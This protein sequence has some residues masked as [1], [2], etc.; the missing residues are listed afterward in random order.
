[1]N[2]NI[3]QIIIILLVFVVIAIGTA[4]VEY[5]YFHNVSESFFDNSSKAWFHE[6]FATSKSRFYNISYKCKDNVCIENET[7]MWDIRFVNLGQEV[8]EITS[9]RLMDHQSL[10]ELLFYNKSVIKVDPEMRGELQINTTAFILAEER[11]IKFFPCFTIRVPYDAWDKLDE[12]VSTDYYV[13]RV[14]EYCYNESYNIS[15]MECR[16]NSYCDED[17]ECKENLC[18]KLECGECQHIVEHRCVDWQCCKA[19]DCPENQT[20]VEHFCRKLFCKPDEIIENH[21]CRSCNYDEFLEDGKCKKLRCKDD[22]VAAN[23]SCKKLICRDNEIAANHSCKKLKCGGDEVAKNHKC[24]KLSCA[25]DEV[26]KNHKCVKLECMFF[27]E[28]R[29]HKCYTDKML[30]LSIIMEAVAWFIIFTV[31]GL[32]LK[33]YHK[34]HAT[35]KLL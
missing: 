14:L 26:A 19:E 16:D 7:I 17:E 5:D 9:L 34:K 29:N 20:C 12:I 4:G 30:V 25:E 21:S 10:E 23:H 1:M 2:L 31:I 33:K 28:V 8:L 6:K 35:T 15:V 27:Q 18:S 32:I 11:L 24:V 13:K 22:E 3:S